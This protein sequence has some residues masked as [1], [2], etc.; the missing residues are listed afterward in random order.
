MKAETPY[1]A[2]P[3]PITSK[4]I[5]QSGVRMGSI[6]VSDAGALH[7]L[8]GRP[9]EAGRQV[10]VRYAPGEE[11]TS[12]RG[13]L[14]QTPKETNVRTRV[15]EYGGGAYL[16]AP[17]SAG[18]GIIYSEFTSQRLFWTKAG[19]EAP[20][21]L[22]PDF[23]EGRYRFADGHLDPSSGSMVVVREDH[24]PNGD[25]APKDVVN[26]V[27]SL[28]LDGSGAMTLLA[29]GRDFYA[30]P[31]LS[32]D[33]G[34]LAYV[35]WDHPSMPWDSTELRV[36]SVRTAADT[37]DTSAH[38]LADGADGDTSVL[39]PAWH[40]LSG[41]L[42][43]VSDASGFYQIMRMPPLAA[44]AS[45]LTPPASVTAGE[46]DFGG[47]SPGWSLSEQGYAFLPDGTL[48]ASYPDRATGRS[49]LLL[50]DDDDDVAAA[51]A[52]RR[53]LAQGD[54]LPY[55]FGSL[56]PAPDGTTMYMLGGAP[57][58]PSGVYAWR[59]CG[60]PS[61]E[62]IAPA[63]MLACSSSADVDA[64][65]VSVPEPVT[66]PS[67]LGASYGYYYPPANAECECTTEAAPPLLVKAHGGPTSCTSTGFNPSVQFWTSR[68]FAVL[69]VD[70]GG[71]TGYGK[72]YRRRLRKS[73]GIVDVDDVCAGAEYLVS[74]GL[75]DP[76]RL[77]IDGGSA[78][79]FTTL[80][81][82]T[83]PP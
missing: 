35:T 81:R 36:T 74:K 40:P 69:D 62:P 10:V 83:P 52:S 16:L 48:V 50:M 27:V 28:K 56:T 49:Q 5:T 79:G 19:T 29:T 47:K 11:G 2:W 66:F 22:T 42:Y 38:M 55:M 51:I 46:V 37:P 73:W 34:T 7:W 3:S 68:G 59:G 60:T 54:G 24:G 23:P 15:H 25:A 18:G 58:A 67:P 53:V 82:S 12:S 14:D 13:A 63:E 77:C 71:S 43:W 4:L 9:Q 33:G 72:E 64:G 57:D 78:G 8:E 75:A 61:G 39:Q 80:G 31:R 32:A 44:G 20:M 70:Y 1:G 76:K 6:S 26:E 65:F 41:A 30:H 17:S 21:A 45:S